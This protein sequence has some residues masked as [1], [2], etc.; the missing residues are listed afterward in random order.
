VRSEE[1]N[2]KRQILEETIARLLLEREAKARGVS[3]GDLVRVEIEAKAAPVTEAEKKAAFEVAMERSPDQPGPAVLRQVET[4]LRQRRVNER[5]Q[6]FLA[7]LREKAGV[8]VLLEV[9]RVE[10]EAG[11][12]AATRGPAQAPVTIVAFSE[13]QCAYCARVAPTLKQLQAHYGDKLRVVFRHLPLPMHREA[14]KAAE[15]ASCAQEQGKFW[16]MH[17]RLFENQRGLYPP[18][19]KRYAVEL[20]LNT[21]QFNQ[22]LDTG[23]YAGRWKEDSSEASRYGITGTP[24]FFI[25]GRM[26]IGAAPYEHFARVID[27]ELEWLG[28]SPSPPR[29]AVTSAAQPD[30]PSPPAP[31]KPKQ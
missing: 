20:G 6:E 15:A 4:S 16:E 29:P 30:A 26:L 27:E 10:V 28:A 1:Y 14:P 11:D 3:V 8:R 19:L 9:P 22:C 17:D 23:K 13:F 12:G 24:A 21:E 5:R 18:D 31:A 7:G 25:N 2:L